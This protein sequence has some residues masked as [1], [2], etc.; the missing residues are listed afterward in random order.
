MELLISHF[1]KDSYVRNADL[2]LA[3]AT[4]AGHASEE[5]KR[6]ARELEKQQVS[7]INRVRHDQEKT[8]KTKDS[9]NS[10]YHSDDM[11][12]NENSVAA[13][14]NEVTAQPMA[15]A[16]E[17]VIGKITLLFDVLK[18][19]RIVNQVA[20]QHTSSSSSDENDDKFFIDMVQADHNSPSNETQGV[21]TSTSSQEANTSASTLFAINDSKSDWSVTLYMNSTNV[22]FKIDTGAQ[23]HVIPKSLLHK[24]SPQPKLK[25]AAVKLTACNGTPSPVAGTCFA[26]IKHKVQTV[27]TLFIVVDSDSVPFL[28][29]NTCDKLMSTVLAK[30]LV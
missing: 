26:R 24:M 4:E 2:T 5:T 16:A 30:L 8:S 12:R 29:L 11:S 23:C 20:G 28:G 17:L 25:A 14:I 18:T 6:H 27:L 13:H 9:R 1:E 21:T 10:S 15:N 22:T 7:E 19:Q 3:K